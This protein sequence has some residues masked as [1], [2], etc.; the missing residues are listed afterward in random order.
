M[1]WAAFSFIP[2]AVMFNGVFGTDECLV[3][4]I[5]DVVTGLVDGLNHTLP[6]GLNVPSVDYF[7]F[8]WLLLVSCAMSLMKHCF[9]LLGCAIQVLE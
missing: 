1:I 3:I 2:M 6:V 7:G 5:M 4:E 9:S 8:L